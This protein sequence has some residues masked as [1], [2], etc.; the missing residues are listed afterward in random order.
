MELFLVL[1]INFKIELS[2]SFD[3]SIHTKGR[4]VLSIVME[5]SI[6]Q[7]FSTSDESVSHTY[8]TRNFTRTL[9]Q[10]DDGAPD[11]KAHFCFLRRLEAFTC[12]S[13]YWIVDNVNKWPWPATL[14]CLFTIS[15]QCV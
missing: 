14:L 13:K 3:R 9:N 5:W 15:I 1:K 6:F 7:M 11:Y 8:F 10:N 12:S 2:F 4:S